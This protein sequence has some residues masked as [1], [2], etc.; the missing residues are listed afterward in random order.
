MNGVGTISPLNGGQACRVETGLW[1][2]R[3]DHPPGWAVPLGYTEWSSRQGP[4]KLE[5]VLQ[6][7]S[8]GV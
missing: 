3:G 6:G 2:I 1:K 8:K 5:K 7:H 4:K